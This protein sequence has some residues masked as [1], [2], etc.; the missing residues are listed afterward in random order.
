MKGDQFQ[1]NTHV[2]ALIRFKK[3]FLNVNVLK[4]Q[5]KI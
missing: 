4:N 1:Y 5:E 3:N 2:K